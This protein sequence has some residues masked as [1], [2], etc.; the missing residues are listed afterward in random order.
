MKKSLTILLTGTLAL[1]T[2]ACG[3]QKNDTLGESAARDIRCYVQDYLAAVDEPYAKEI[4][5]TMAYDEAYLSNEMDWRTAG[6]D[7]EHAA[8]DYLAKEMESIGLAD[9]EKIPVTVDKW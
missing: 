3:G 4:A 9:V 1:D 8:A 5:K 6:S 2:C 7:A